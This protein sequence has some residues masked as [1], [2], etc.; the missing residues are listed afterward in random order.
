[1]QLPASI[2]IFPRMHVSSQTA[3]WIVLLCLL[4]FQAQV[5]AGIWLDC[6]NS[7]PTSDVADCPMHALDRSVD[8]AFDG[9]QLLKCAKCALAVAF[10]VIH[11]LPSATV[12][13]M[14]PAGSDRHAN[15]ASVDYCFFPDRAARPPDPSTV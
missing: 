15:P 7:N 13:R 12:V 9:E 6:K 10:G 8:V 5:M 4:T 2:T 14:L 11:G 1:M 3:R